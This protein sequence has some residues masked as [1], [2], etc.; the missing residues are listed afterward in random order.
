VET[1]LKSS[2]QNIFDTYNSLKKQTE[3]KFEV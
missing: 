2:L 1:L 3:K